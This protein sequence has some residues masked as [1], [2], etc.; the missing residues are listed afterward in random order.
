MLVDAALETL[1][2]HQG[3]ERLYAWKVEQIVDTER[4]G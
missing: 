3:D 4:G 2:G 1:E